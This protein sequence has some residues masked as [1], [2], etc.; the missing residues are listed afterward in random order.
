MQLIDS[1]QRGHPVIGGVIVVST[2]R[3]RVGVATGRNDPGS[4]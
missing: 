2:V 3:K 1:Q 4:E